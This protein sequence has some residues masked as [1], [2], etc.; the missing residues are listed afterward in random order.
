[1]FKSASIRSPTAS[2]LV[3]VWSSMVLHEQRPSP[4]LA[5]KESRGRQ[6]FTKKGL[7][8]SPGLK[9]RGK[10]NDNHGYWGGQRAP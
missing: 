3:L 9:S 7:S 10:N 1:M 5:N 4:E 8:L 2:L 6:A